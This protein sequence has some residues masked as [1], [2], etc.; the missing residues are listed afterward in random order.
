MVYSISTFVYLRAT[1]FP[2]Y[3]TPSVIMA[4]ARV[5]ALIT[6]PLFRLFIT[7]FI[8]PTATFC[9]KVSQEW[10]AQR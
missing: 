9:L 7:V 1:Q 10:W 3:H 6:W 4:L 2:Y 8:Q 5:S